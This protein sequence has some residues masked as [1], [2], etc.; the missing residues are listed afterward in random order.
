M[1][2]LGSFFEYEQE[3]N[4]DLSLAFRKQISACQF[5][6]IPEIC[7]AVVNMPARRFWV[8]EERA[9]IVI[10]SMLRGDDLRNMRQNKREMFLEI[11]NRV[12]KLKEEYPDA[13]ISQLVF[14][15]VN[16]PAPKFYMTPLSAKVIFYKIKRKW[17]EERKRK[18][19]FLF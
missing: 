8:S 10:S 12:M 18:L 17:Y 4:E 7:K 2:A 11:Y 14:K 13:S 19:R 16:Q 5:I 6:S 15:V 1:K 3:R 9:T